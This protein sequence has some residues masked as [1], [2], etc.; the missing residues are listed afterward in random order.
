[1]ISRDRL[2]A[3]KINRNKENIILS[4]YL[5]SIITN[6]FTDPF[7]HHPTSHSSS[8]INSINNPIP[9]NNKSNIRIFKWESLCSGLRCSLKNLSLNFNTSI[10][11]S[12]SCSK[13][14][15]KISIIINYLSTKSSILSK[16]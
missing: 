15:T 4:L 9:S 10:S 16:L 8:P 7:M 2:K 5:N 6:S 1:M 11:K 13:F 3:N 14:P 12:S